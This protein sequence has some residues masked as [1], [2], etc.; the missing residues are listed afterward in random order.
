MEKLRKAHPRAREATITQGFSK[1]RLRAM[2][3]DPSGYLLVKMQ[4]A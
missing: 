4:N 1:C 3:S 2:V